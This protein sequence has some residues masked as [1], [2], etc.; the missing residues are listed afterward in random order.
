ML[1]TLSELVNLGDLD[2]DA[3]E[4]LRLKTPLIDDLDFRR[5]M[6][7]SETISAW[8][9]PSLETIK[10]VS[11]TLSD[12]SVDWMLRLQILKKVQFLCRKR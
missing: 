1:D 3:Y 7:M 2:A 11:E 8:T 5:I 6:G 4:A 9:W 12:V 10:G